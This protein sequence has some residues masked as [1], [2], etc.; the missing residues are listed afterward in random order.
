MCHHSCLCSVP[1]LNA[2]QAPF[3]KSKWEEYLVNFM[4]IADLPFTFVELPE[5]REFVQYTRGSTSIHI[6][7]ADTIKRRVV[8]LSEK[9]VEELKDFFKVTYM[10]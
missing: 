1:L 8:V 3:N 7:S 6:P 2:P 4:V 10:F 9:T 5:F